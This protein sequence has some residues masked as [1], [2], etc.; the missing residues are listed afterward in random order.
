MQP[1]HPLSLLGMV[2]LN[3]TG[4]EAADHVVLAL[5][6]CLSS[7]S[8]PCAIP[9]P[10]F[11]SQVDS[12]TSLQIAMLILPSPPHLSSSNINSAA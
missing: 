8:S 7:Y 2:L 3:Y 12:K 9:K 5:Q 1:C 6:K 11:L 10:H 4:S